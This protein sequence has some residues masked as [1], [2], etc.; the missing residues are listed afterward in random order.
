MEDAKEH[1]THTSTTKTDALAQMPSYAKFLKY[2]L[3]KKRKLIDFE[4]VKLSEDVQ[5]FCKINYLQS[6]KI[7]ALCDLGASINLMS[8][9]C[10]EKLGI[11]EV[12]PTTI[13]LQLA[14]RSI[15]Y[16]LGVIEDVLVKV[17]KFIF[18]FDFVMLDMEE[19]R[20]IPLILDRP[21]LA[22]GRAL[23]DVEKGE[24]VLR[25]NDEKVTFN[26][27]R[28]MK[29]LGSSDCYRIDAI[30]D[31][32]ECSVQDTFIEDPLEML[33]VNP[34]STESD[35]EEVEECMNY[36]EGSKPL[37]RS[38]NSKIGELENI[39]KSLKPSIEEILFLELKPL[40]PN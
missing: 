29:Y 3:T 39:P 10:F 12:K 9:S 15:K 26:V 11:G 24:L 2:I 27:F 14:D 36:L 20:E 22:T 37:P 32:V 13:P 19:D 7:Q 8:Y 18:P 34:K 4:T 35:R 33:L 30:D 38:L 25:L 5:L 28:S 6:L 16:P 40:P 23:I 31:I 1:N 17:D 21:F